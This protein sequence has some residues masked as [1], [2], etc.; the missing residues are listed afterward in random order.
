MAE[1]Y[2]KVERKADEIPDNEIR[3]KANSGIGRYLRRVAQLW[4]E[5][6][7]EIVIR[8]VSNAMENVVKLAELIKHRFPKIHQIN[9]ID[10]YEFVD[11][12]EPLYEGMEPLKHTRKVTMLSITLSK[13]AKDTQNYGYQ[14]PI[15]DSE[16]KPYEENVDRP[17]KTP[18]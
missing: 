15:P 5:N 17:K 2:R 9:K 13:S 7:E 14:L 18:R 12:W 1:A 8:G 16:V 3:V 4:G 11:E 6:K 10:D